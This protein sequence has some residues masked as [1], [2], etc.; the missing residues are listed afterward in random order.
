MRSTRWGAE[1]YIEGFS[2]DDRYRDWSKQPQDELNILHKALWVVFTIASVGSVQISLIHW[3]V[4]YRNSAGINSVNVTFLIFN[5]VF[6]TV[7]LLIS[8]IPVV[9][10]HFIYSHVMQSMYVLFTFI[11]WAAGGTAAATSDNSIFNALDF[12]KDPFWACVF[13]FMYLIIFQILAHIYCL[14]LCTF[15]KWLVRKCY[16]E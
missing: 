13:V 14:A 3:I 8:N 15:R 4:L 10:L 2:G 7:E 16:C 1:P 9:L 11:Y 5:S 6:I 12:G